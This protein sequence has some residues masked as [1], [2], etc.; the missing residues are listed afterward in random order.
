MNYHFLYGCDMI[1]TVKKT[2]HENRE[3][4]TQHKRKG[5]YNYGKEALFREKS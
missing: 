1:S 2:R 5:D 3:K 4:L